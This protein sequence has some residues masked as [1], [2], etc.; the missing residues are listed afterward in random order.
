MNEL[1]SPITT[2]VL[3]V[4]GYQLYVSLKLVKSLAYERKQKAAQ[5]VF[6]WALPILGATVVHWFLQHGASET[7]RDRTDRNHIPQGKNHYGR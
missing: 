6:V 5:L 4:L 3:G 7:G 1:L 2:I